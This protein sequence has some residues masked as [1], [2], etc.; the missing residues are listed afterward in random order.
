MTK[1][2]TFGPLATHFFVMSSE[3]DAVQAAYDFSVLND[4]IIERNGAFVSVQC[5]PEHSDVVIDYV[6][7]TKG[8]RVQGQVRVDSERPPHLRL[9]EDCESAAS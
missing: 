2:R 8:L 4:A 5:Y 9:Q 1:R 6:V 3:A 7:C